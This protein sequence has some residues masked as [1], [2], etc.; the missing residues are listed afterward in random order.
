MSAG[1]KGKKGVG[2]SAEE[3][4]CRRH[5]QNLLLQASTSGKLESIIRTSR[6][7]NNDNAE[8]K[9]EQ[10]TRNTG[11]ISNTLPAQASQKDDELENLRKQ[12]KHTLCD[13]VASGKL[14]QLFQQSMGESSETSAACSEVDGL[15]KELR[16]TL[17]E[18]SRNGTL[19][20]VIARHRSSR[21]SQVATKMGG[22][23]T[24]R[25]WDGKLVAEKTEDTRDL[26][27]LLLELG[28]TSAPKLGRSKKKGKSSIKPQGNHC[29]SEQLTAELPISTG[30]VVQEECQQSSDADK[31]MQDACGEPAQVEQVDE[32]QPLLLLEQ[33]CPFEDWNIVLSRSSGRNSARARPNTET[34]ESNSV[35]TDVQVES[36]AAGTISQEMRWASP[37]HLRREAA[38][39]AENTAGR[40]FGICLQAPS[41]SERRRRNLP[42]PPIGLPPTPP[43]VD[44]QNTRKPTS[45][46]GVW[47]SPC[48]MEALKMIPVWPTTPE[49]TPPSSPRHDFNVTE[50]LVP[51]PLYLLADVQ[52]LLQAAAAKQAENARASFHPN[53]AACPVDPMLF[54]RGQEQWCDNRYNPVEMPDDFV[55]DGAPCGDLLG[56]PGFGAPQQSCIS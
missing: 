3:E 55:D 26:D 25:G 18:A 7:Q 38:A 27:Q 22:P 11:R 30:E 39:L 43:Q 47:K 14:A 53:A 4:M 5:L 51:I 50:V 33:D 48:R 54:A 13:A 56:K 28:E 16:N 34:L 45:E 44:C 29:K 17:A 21:A 52:Q 9:A 19:N 37:W 24:R 46:G 42:P 20:D 8:T 35:S 1:Q 36:C 31:L 23:Q 41:D 15:R 49:F 40:D 2:A 12:A 10:P 32:D 6:E